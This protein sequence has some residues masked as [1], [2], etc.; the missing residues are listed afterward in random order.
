MHLSFWYEFTNSVAIEIGL[1]HL[2][3]FT[4]SHNHFLILVES[5]T[6]QA[7]LQRKNKSSIARCEPSARQC[8]SRQGTADIRHTGVI[9]LENSKHPSYCL[10]SWSRTWKFADSPKI[11]TREWLFVNGCEC[12]SPVSTATKFFNTSKD[13]AN[14]N[15]S[16]YL[17]T[18]ILTARC[19][20]VRRY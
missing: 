3:Q 5:A 20:A 19:Y 12:N 16:T 9:S 8:N 17:L 13:G 1:L 10:S 7:F 4:N 2:Q 14:A 18:D 11:R 6:F 15:A